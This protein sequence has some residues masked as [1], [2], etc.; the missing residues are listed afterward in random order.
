KPEEKTAA[1]EGADFIEIPGA[2][3]QDP[4]RIPVEEAVAAYRERSALQER[5]HQIISEVRTGAE[6]QVGGYIQQQREAAQGIVQ[7]L[8]TWMK[9][10]P[11]PQPPPADWTNPNTPNY[12]PEDYHY[13]RANYEAAMGAINQ[14]HMQLQQAQKHESELARQQEAQRD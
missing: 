6:R 1:N 8:T 14:V 4:E 13:A 2:E 5:A 10:A 12:K 11:M 3:G 7:T 9:P